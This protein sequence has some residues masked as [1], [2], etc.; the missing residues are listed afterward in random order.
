GYGFDDVIVGASGYVNGQTDEGRALVYPVP[1]RRSSVPP[2]W[3]AE[4]DQTFAFFGMSVGTAGDVNGD[5]F[6]DVIVGAPFYD[7]GQTDEGRAYVYLGSASGLA[8][9]P[10]WI[11]ESDQAS[12]HFGA[13]VATAGDV[14]GDGRADLIVGAPLFDNGQTDEGRAFVYLGTAS[15]PA[16]TAAWTSESNQAGADHGVSVAWAGDVNGDGYGDVI[17]GADLY[18]NGQTDEGRAFVYLG[19]AS[20]LAAAFAWSAES[21]QAGAHFGGCVSGAGDTNGDG[22]ADL[23]VGASL[24]DNGQTDEGRAFVYLGSASGPAATAVWTAESDQ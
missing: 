1:A 12:A 7:N 6:D 24:Y 23:I 19:S 5:G 4:G 2:A 8:A 15:G 20:G 11:A 21:N 9:S 17:V 18:D 22:Y 10:V 16:A 14:N 3:T 13:S